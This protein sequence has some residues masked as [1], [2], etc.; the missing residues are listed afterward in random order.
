MGKN[1]E[2]LRAAAV[3]ALDPPAA[4]VDEVL[5]LL[6]I[7]R[8]LGFA[9]QLSYDMVTYPHAA[10]IKPVRRFKELNT[11]ATRACLFG[12][13]CSISAGIYSLWKHG[14]RE[15]LV[16]RARSDL[17]DEKKRIEKSVAPPPL[18]NLSSLPFI[19]KHANSTVIAPEAVPQCVCNW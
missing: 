10:K 4:G 13:A 7:G 12:L 9:V 17:T 1:I 6:T 16:K 19:P 14:E 5:K 15:K 8:Q 3:A 2:H 11:Q 18:H